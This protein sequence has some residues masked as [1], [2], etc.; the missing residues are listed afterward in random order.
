MKAKKVRN[1][2]KDP[3]AQPT[4]A[5]MKA[6]K[7]AYTKNLFMKDVLDKEKIEPTSYTHLSNF[8]PTGQ[9]DAFYD[10]VVATVRSIWLVN[11]RSMLERPL[12]KIIEH[13]A[14]N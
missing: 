3:N 12:P 5:Q 7:Y 6:E 10:N 14:G 1:G 2:G 11:I 4:E 9:E 8:A 13:L